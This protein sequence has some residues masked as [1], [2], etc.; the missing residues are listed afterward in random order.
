MWDP[1]NPPPFEA[2]RL[3]WH[4]PSSVAQRPRW[5]SF[6]SP[7]DVGSPNPPPFEAQRPC[8]HTP[9]F[10]AQCPRWPLF[11]TP[12]FSAHCPRWPLFLSSIDVGSPNP[13]PFGIQ[14]PCWHTALL[15]HCLISTSPHI[16]LLWGLAVLADTLPYIHLASYP[17]PLRL[18]LLAGTSPDVQP[19]YHL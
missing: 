4:T 13:P 10:R 18:S 9:S 2:Q 19:W 5:H 14:R 16:H 6:P 8:W 1:L 3:C 12:S 17:P 11:H 15:T 7:I